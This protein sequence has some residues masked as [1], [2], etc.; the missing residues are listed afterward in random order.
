[1][2]GRFEEAEKLG[3]KCFYVSLMEARPKEESLRRVMWLGAK[4]FQKFL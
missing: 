2:R 1:M 4:T 3:I